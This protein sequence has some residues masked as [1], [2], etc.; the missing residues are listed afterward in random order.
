MKLYTS[1]LH[2]GHKNILK[3][4][5]RP[6]SNVDEMDKGLIERWNAKVT[7]EDDVYVLG[8]LTF[9]KD[10]VK[11]RELVSKLKGKIH[12]IRG[13][14][15][16]YNVIEPIRDLLT[17]VRDYAVIN[18]NDRRVIL[19][20]YPIFNWQD[21]KYGSYHLYGHIHSMAE[22]ALDIPKAYNVGVDVCDYQP[23]TLDELI[24]HKPLYK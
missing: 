5:A 18:D 3:Y 23:L 8:D 21:Q 12:L 20:H 1:D 4:E 11:N 17:S 19:F 13:N 16:Y 10:K 7:N 14:H 22:Y 24:K 9:Y 15:D 6:W 2:F